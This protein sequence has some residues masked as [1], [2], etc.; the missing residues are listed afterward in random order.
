MEANEAGLASPTRE[1]LDSAAVSFFEDLFSMKVLEFVHDI[2]RT[3]GSS[4]VSEKQFVKEGSATQEEVRFVSLCWCIFPSVQRMVY[5]GS[6]A[7]T[8]VAGTSVA[9]TSL[10]CTC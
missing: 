8:S 2:Q 1:A 7:G 6:C 5:S 4:S 9:G 3:I 10:M